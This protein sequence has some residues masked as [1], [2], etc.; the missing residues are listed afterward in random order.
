MTSIKGR[1]V[2]AFGKLHLVESLLA[3]GFIAAE[4][5]VDI[6]VDIIACDPRTG[7]FVPIQLKA[8]TD[9]RFTIDARYKDSVM[10][11]VWN[12]RKGQPEVYAMTYDESYAIAE[13]RGY[14]KSES[15]KKHQAYSVV[16]SPELRSQLE[17]YR[18][19]S[20]RWR[21]LLSQPTV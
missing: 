1:Y 17:E 10:A 18:A 8:S 16:P 4:P 9:S 14:L 21:K 20:D 5:V 7:R 11:L 13:Q 12:C 3:A 6:G 19:T 2:E 15:W